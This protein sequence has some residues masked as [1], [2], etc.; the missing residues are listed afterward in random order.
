MTRRGRRGAVAPLLCAVVVLAVLAGAIGLTPLR[1]PGSLVASKRVSHEP[2]RYVPRGTVR[3]DVGHG[4]RAAAIFRP[5]HATA[6]EPV[7]VFLHGWAAVDPRRYGRWVGHLARS[8]ATVVYPA[9]QER[10]YVHTRMLLTYTLAAVR[11][12]LLRFPVHAGRLFVVG[13][14]AGAALAA[15][16]AAAAGAAGLPAPAA[17]M[18]VYPGR[19]IHAVPHPIPATDLST[20]AAGTRLLVLFGERDTAV[21]SKDARQIAAAAVHA[22]VTLSMVSDDAVDFHGAPRDAG[23]AARHAFWAP[24]DRLIAGAAR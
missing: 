13:H 21:G 6:D 4:A 19:R 18:S 20:I 5:I 17:V 22:D 14:S 8:G 15:D 12:A 2:G 24:L 11:S 1:N 9:Y 10:P 23:R 7:V 16:F 3:I